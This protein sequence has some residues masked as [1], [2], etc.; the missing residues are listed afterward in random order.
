MNAPARRKLAALALTLGLVALPACGGESPPDDEP[1]QGDTSAE[2]AG[3]LVGAEELGDGWGVQ[4]MGP[5]VSFEDGVVTDENRDYLPRMEFCPEASDDSQEAARRLEWQAFQQFDYDT[6]MVE[7]TA[8]PTPGSPPPKHHLVF[9]QEFL[10]QGEA[11]DIE[12]TYAAIAAGM[13]ACTGQ[14][15]EYPD[16]ETGQS[17]PL[18]MPTIGDEA[19]GTR[20]IVSEPGPGKRAATWDLR[21]MLI[22]DDEYLVG[23]TFAEIRSPGVERQ[24]DDATIADLVE[25]VVA[26]LP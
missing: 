5:D 14:T 6:G 18:D 2:V 8:E 16:G 15:N 26:E 1:A 10:L 21:N 7:P 20:E 13:E 11:A 22:R 25:T 4:D 9:L 19:T 24:F 23:V 12:D 3:L 17:E